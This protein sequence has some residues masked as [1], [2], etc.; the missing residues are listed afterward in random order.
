MKA[1]LPH[2][3]FI[4]TKAGGSRGGLNPDTQFSLVQRVS[5]LTDRNNW[6][7]PWFVISILLLQSYG[8]LSDM[9]VLTSSFH[10]PLH[11]HPP[12]MLVLNTHGILHLSYQVNKGFRSSRCLHTSSL[13]WH[14]T[15][16]Y[17]DKLQIDFWRH[18]LQHFLRV[19]SVTTPSCQRG[20]DSTLKSVL[21]KVYA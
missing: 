9:T 4:L 10:G 1:N 12:M 5:R 21:S 18:L 3:I 15:K 20:L 8:S 11:V 6:W 16:W 13:S 19:N 7:K 17:N 14:N 2:Q